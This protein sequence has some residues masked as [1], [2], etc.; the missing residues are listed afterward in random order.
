MIVIVVVVCSHRAYD[1]D[2]PETDGP[3]PWIPDG[4]TYPIAANSS[5]SSALVHS[6]EANTGPK[7]QRAAIGVQWMG[8]EGK[9]RE[10]AA[11]ET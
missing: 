3:R 11:V 2:E 10:S 5:G 1:L 8:G 7:K 4:T 9:T 6:P